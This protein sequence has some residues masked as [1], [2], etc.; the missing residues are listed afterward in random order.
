VFAGMI[1][2]AFSVL[3]RLELYSPGVQY[4]QGD[5]QSTSFLPIFLFFFL[6]F[7]PIFLFYLFRALLPSP[8]WDLA[9]SFSRLNVILSFLFKK[10]NK[11]LDKI[12]KILDK[13]KI[14]KQVSFFKLLGF[15]D[16][17]LFVIVISFFI[18]DLVKVCAYFVETFS[19]IPFGSEDCFLQ[20]NNNSGIPNNYGFLG[21]SA[22]DPSN[23]GGNHG[24]SPQ[25]NH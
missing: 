24:G 15:M 14:L 7:L 11:I 20:M 12:K 3:I 4:L 21:N 8:I 6:L 17:I 19:I 1:I 9:F 18:F 2:T 5:N 16:Y 23:T 22:G 25:G 10:G 13:I